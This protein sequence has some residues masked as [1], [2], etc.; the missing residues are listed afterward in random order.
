MLIVI[1]RKLRCRNIINNK[2][3]CKGV[4]RVKLGVNNDDDAGIVY[5]IAHMTRP[6]MVNDLVRMS[7]TVPYECTIPYLYGASNYGIK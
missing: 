4:R 1:I 5:F 7:R 6:V 3:A 2:D